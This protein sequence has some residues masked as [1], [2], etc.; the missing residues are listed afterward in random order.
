MKKPP[1]KRNS[2]LALLPSALGTMCFIL[3]LGACKEKEA[4]TGTGGGG[5]PPG[6]DDS[7]S[8]IILTSKGPDGE[9]K[10]NWTSPTLKKSAKN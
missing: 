10:I 9:G 5:D 3:M 7:S 6:N 2:S 4:P 8:K 1:M